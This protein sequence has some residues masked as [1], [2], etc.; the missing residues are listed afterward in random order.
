MPQLHLM[1]GLP[2][3]GKTTLAKKLE[4][5]LPALRLSPDEWMERVAGGAMDDPDKRDAVEAEQWRIAAR[6]LALGVNVVLENGFWTRKE[7]DAY[8]ACGREIG[9]QIVLHYLTAPR[10]ELLWRIAKRQV[11]A[12]P[13]AFRIT[14]EMFALYESWFEPPAADELR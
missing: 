13:N 6:A 12:P 10:E 8:R 9:A 14:P 5:D 11:N 2:G 4:Q 1:V 3:A 7:R